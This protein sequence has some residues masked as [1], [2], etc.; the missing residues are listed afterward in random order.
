M[1]D[2]NLA[3]IADLRDRAE[4]A[5]AEA[6]ALRSEVDV[7]R[8]WAWTHLL[9]KRDREIEHT[10]GPRRQRGIVRWP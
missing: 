9:L 2:V 8:R 6:R 4:H 1:P 7:L 10:L 5:C 3:E